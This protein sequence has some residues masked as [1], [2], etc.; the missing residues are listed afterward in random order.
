MST[1]TAL[2]IIDV[3]PTFM[4]GGELPVR[5][6]GEVIAPALA[7]A[8]R[9]DLFDV[10][11]ATQDWHPP[12]H[13]SFASSHQGGEPFRTV[14]VP[15][16]EQMLW[17][18]HALQGTPSAAVASPEIL[19]AVTVVIRKG[20]RAGVDSYSAFFE[21]DGTDTGL[22]GLLR[23]RGIGRV[24]LCGLAT[25]Y[26]VKFSALGAA[27]SGFE[28]VVVADACRGIAQGADLDATWTELREAGVAV[29]D[30]LELDDLLRR[31]RRRDGEP[32]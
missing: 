29:T 32:A 22:A 1:R 26:C 4:P 24:V 9:R 23:G 16:G 13:V 25:D 12:G 14:T 31:P 6:G 5:G 8:R 15:Y 17:P 30:M 28:T 19:D 10:S 11:F 18:D 21:A 2:G 7:L 3:Q 20:T 27:S